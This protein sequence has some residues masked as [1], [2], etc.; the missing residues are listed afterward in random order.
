MYPTRSSWRLPRCCMS[1]PLLTPLVPPLDSPG[2]ACPFGM[3]LP[4]H[5]PFSSCRRP[6]CGILKH[7]ETAQVWPS[8]KSP[9]L[10]SHT[11]PSKKGGGGKGTFGRNI[12]GRI[13]V[14]YCFSHPFPPSLRVLFPPR[15]L[16]CFWRKAYVSCSLGQLSQLRYCRE[17]RVC[18][19]SLW[20]R[21]FGTRRPF[22]C[23]FVFVLML[24]MGLVTHSF[25]SFHFF[26]FFML[27][28]GCQKLLKY[29]PPPRGCH[30][31]YKV[32]YVRKCQSM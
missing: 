30:M 1:L 13:I 27:R 2:V 20:P 31:F 10:F 11:P 32:T 28:M 15:R 8:G 22:F 18:S 7:L 26:F 14:M 9:S 4:L 24:R 21:S 17:R 3:S 25:H 29:D 12:E 16:E 23:L 5:S 19:R 6:S